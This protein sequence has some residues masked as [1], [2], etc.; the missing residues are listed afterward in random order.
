MSTSPLAKLAPL[1][2]LSHDQS[3]RLYDTISS[4]YKK[5]PRNDML[6]RICQVT[7][8]A[9]RDREVLSR[10]ILLTAKL[11]SSQILRPWI[12]ENE[13]HAVL[14][15]LLCDKKNSKYLGSDKEEIDPRL[16]KPTKKALASLISAWSGRGGTHSAGARIE[17]WLDEIN[18]FLASIGYR[19][20]RWLQDFECPSEAYTNIRS[21]LLDS[22]R[23][24]AKFITWVSHPHVLPTPVPP[25]VKSWYPKHRACYPPR[26]DEQVLKFLFRTGAITIHSCEDYHSRP[27]KGFDDYEEFFVPSA[28]MFH[29]AAFDHISTHSEEP[30]SVA[31]T[32]IRFC[33]SDLL[34]ICTDERPNCSKCPLNAV[35]LSS[36]TRGGDPTIL[37]SLPRRHFDFIS[38]TPQPRTQVNCRAGR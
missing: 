12:S 22:R 17:N 20:V 5:V 29:A 7:W 19:L 4:R 27:E 34:G 21:K 28:L 25:L 32:I 26:I 1:R 3:I 38:P 13:A 18:Y 23:A 6:A 2:A 35:C 30:A 36:Q 14:F 16:Y 24:S 9:F 10:T 33:D 11:G 37:R 8:A 31:E 15:D